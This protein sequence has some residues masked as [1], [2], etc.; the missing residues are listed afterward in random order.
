MPSGPC[1]NPLIL[2]LC[3][4]LMN[5]LI[6]RDSSAATAQPYMHEQLHL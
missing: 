5:A 2:S 6:R 1:V 3:H 4:A